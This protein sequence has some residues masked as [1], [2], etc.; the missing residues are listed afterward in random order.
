MILFGVKARE[1]VLQLDIE[2]IQ[3]ELPLITGEPSRSGP[4]SWT[5]E[6]NP[7]SVVSIVKTPVLVPALGGA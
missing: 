2:L 4:L 7:W 3:K 5:I 6:R 1:F